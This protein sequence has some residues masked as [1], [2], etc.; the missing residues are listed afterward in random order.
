MIELTCEVCGNIFQRQ[1]G[2]YNRS[3]K[4]GRKSYCSRTCTGKVVGKNLIGHRSD[5]DISK[6]SSNR[7]DEFT[8]FRLLF[9]TAKRRAEEKDNFCEN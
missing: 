9:R 1:K 4:K 3:L 5:Y 6:H 8:P 2:E 7:N